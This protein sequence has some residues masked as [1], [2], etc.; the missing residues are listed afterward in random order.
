M[1]MRMTDTATHH[2]STKPDRE[3]LVADDVVTASSLAT[4]LGCTRQNIARLTAEAV[5]TKRS[6]GCYDQTAN[7]LKYIRHLRGGFRSSP[8]SQID[9]EH[10]A[11]KTKMLQSKLDEREG[12]LVP[13]ED[14]ID[15]MSTMHGVFLTGLGGFAARIGERDLA[16]RKRIDKAV[17]D[18]RVDLAKQMSALADAD[19]E[20][21]EPPE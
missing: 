2:A 9:I 7:R 11:V 18:L 1:E 20:P 6:D 15:M 14:A 3:K 12:R 19:G 5:L 21:P 17:F 4:H 10:T 16:L 8:R 13:A